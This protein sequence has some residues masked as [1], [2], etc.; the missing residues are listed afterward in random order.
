MS[1]RVF[2]GALL[3]ST[4]RFLD[5]FDLTEG[6]L[7]SFEATWSGRG[8]MFGRADVFNR[9]GALVATFSQDAMAR[10]FPDGQDHSDDH[11][12]IL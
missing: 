6:V 2:S 3:T 7:M 4:V 1:H 11:N 12:W 8:R 10:P 9:D 5:R